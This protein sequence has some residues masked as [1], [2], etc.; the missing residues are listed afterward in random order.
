MVA[1]LAPDATL[2]R[3]FQQ[4]VTAEAFGLDGV[5]R[6]RIIANERGMLD[7]KLN[8][9][10]NGAAVGHPLDRFNVVWDSPSK[11]SSGSMP[12]GNGDIGLNVW[13][14]ESGDLVFYISK[15]DA[16]DENGR[17][18]KLGRVRVKLDPNPFTPAVP[19]RQTLKL[20]EAEI[21]V[22]GG[23]VRRCLEYGSMPSNA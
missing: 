9:L 3:D 18:I 5:S 6:L 15:T 13:V 7:M 21:E 16:W 4:H 22:T 20:H 17:L 8:S 14:E 12:I 2:L 23:G 10:E 19:Y 1:T 11:D